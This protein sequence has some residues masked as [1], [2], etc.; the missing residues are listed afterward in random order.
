M[1]FSYTTV[2]LAA[3]S[4][5]ALFYLVAWLTDKGKVP[6][7]IITH[8]ALYVLSLGVVVSTW[9]FYTA[10]ISASNRGYGFNAYYIGYGAAFLFAPMAMYPILQI[11]RTYQLASLADLFAFRFRSP[12]AGTLTTIILLFC[13]FPL[14]ALQTLAV[15]LSTTLI[16]PAAKPHIVALLY[17][18]VIAFFTLRFGTQDVTGRAR[19]DGIVVSLAFES[20]VKILAL[21]TAGL[22]AVYG[23]FGSF[24]DLNEWLVIQPPAN[25]RL[26]FSFLQ[27]STNLLVLLFFTAA[28]AM[29]HMFH[30][31]FHENRNPKNL[32]VASWGVPLLLLCA[33]VPVLPV[34]WAYVQLGSEGNVQFASLLIGLLTEAPIVTLIIY[35]GGIA[36]ACGMMIV[37]AMSVSNMCLN[38]LLLRVKQPPAGTGLYQWL[39][40]CRRLFI[41]S[42]LAGGYFY[43]FLISDGSKV[44]DT[45]NIS[46]IACMQFLPGILTVLYWPTGNSKG[47][48]GGVLAG[49]FMWFVLGLFPMFFNLAFFDIS[50]SSPGVINWNLVASISL[51]TNL[52][53]LV[54]VSLLTTTS[55]EEH[56]AARLCAMDSIRQPAVKPRLVS[57]TPAEFISRLSISLGEASAV[58]EVNQAMSEINLQDNEARPY[59]MQRLRTKLEANLSSLLG[60]TLAHQIIDFALPF[61]P[62]NSEQASINFIETQVETFPHNLSGIA[63]DLDA[64]RR[65]HRQVLQNLPLGVCS[66]DGTGMISIWN[67]AMTKLTGLSGERITGL[68][69]TELPSPWR[70]LFGNFI[71]DPQITHIPKHA[72]II[73]ERQRWLSLHKSNFGHTP[74]PTQRTNTGMTSIYAGQVILV[75]DQTETG[76]LEA[77][78]AHAERLSSVGRLAAGVA[79]EIGNPVTG[80][81]CL[82]Q[83]LRDETLDTEQREMAEQIIEQTHR[84][85]AIVQSLVGFS[86]SG[87][88]ADRP[89]R[90]ERVNLS[91]AAMEAIQLLALQQDDRGVSFNNFCDPTVSIVADHQRIMQILLN[92]LTNARDASPDNA[93]VDVT[94]SSNDD[95]VSLMVTDWGCGIPD[96]LQNRVFD[97]FFTTKDP[98]KGTGLGLS[99]VHRIV[100]DFGGSITIESP[101]ATGSNKGT[102]VIVTFPCY[103]PR[104]VV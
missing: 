48:I 64:L 2:I 90:H 60:P 79:H 65:H 49:V 88:Q 68:H 36:A 42:I 16:A 98:G 6:T 95:F 7:R 85:S 55:M 86:H 3:A 8:P 77:E 57:R 35:T 21:L 5:F 80:I 53:T 32:A 26:E 61:A 39:L 45:G 56:R 62:A 1:M 82:A 103:A 38:H 50:Y 69:F 59:H 66:I 29:P 12:W 24:T 87:M 22:Y 30:M 52:C 76:M 20:V 54:I 10:L 14:L 41:I 37:L 13:V 15:A 46:F 84:I 75:E 40:S 43:Y 81:A 27:N 72:F 91:E 101:A 83:N 17:C 71:A 63:I 4:Y 25:T 67:T 9:S 73:E 19:N 92:L 51:I 102:R 93:E 94:N 44:L 28:I 104:S 11:T 70:G 78:L 33:S 18:M 74:S 100:K 58:R 34:L 31:I 23:I 97:P 47:F 89:S 99:L 96:S